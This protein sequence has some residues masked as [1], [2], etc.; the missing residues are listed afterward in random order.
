MLRRDNGT[1]KA[2]DLSSLLP[3]GL[4]SQHTEPALNALLL[5]EHKAGQHAVLKLLWIIKAK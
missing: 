1:A 3:Y 4:H 5:D 2:I